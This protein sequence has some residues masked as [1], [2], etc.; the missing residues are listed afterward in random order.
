MEEAHDDNINYEMEEQDMDS[1]VMNQNISLKS[2]DSL[3][4]QLQRKIEAFEKK[5]KSKI[6]NYLIM[7]IF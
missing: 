3:I 1:N 7:I 5:Q 4:K 2:K 6:K